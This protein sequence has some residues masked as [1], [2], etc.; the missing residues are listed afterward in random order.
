HR[1]SELTADGHARR[2]GFLPP[3]ELPRRMW[4]G[5]QLHF[6]SPLRLG[7]RLKRVSTIDGV[8]EKTGRTGSLVFVKVRHEIYANDS[9]ASALTD[10]HDIVYREEKRAGA[11]EP[12]PKK[13]PE[14]QKWKRDW[15]PDEVLLFRYSALTFK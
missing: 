7:D 9:P 11:F 3:V 6:K 5:S 15:I 10:L 4:A 14:S 1:R 13:A 12:P 8:E 2:G